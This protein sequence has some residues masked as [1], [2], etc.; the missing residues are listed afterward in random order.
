MLRD[1]RL[2]VTGM[3]LGV[4]LTVSSGR[5]QDVESSNSEVP[6]TVAAGTS[7][8]N[9]QGTAAAN[10]QANSG[11]RG[12]SAT[13]MQLQL[14]Q[15]LEQLPPYTFSFAPDTQSAGALK[16]LHWCGSTTMS[17]L[18]HQWVHRL[19]QMHPDIEII[20]SAEG[21]EIG[22]EKLA[23]DPTLLVGVSRPVDEEDLKRLLA[24][25][26]KEP[27]AV[28]VGLEAMAVFVHKSNPI[29]SVSPAI[30]RSIFAQQA[31]GT[32]QAKLWRDVGVE[33]ELATSTITV[34]ER[35]QNSGSEA[36]ISKVLLSGAKMVP[37]AKPCETNSAV[38]A[39]IAADPSGIGFGDLRYEHPDVRRVPLQVQG[40]IIQ[41]TDG[42]VLSGTYPLMR[43]LLLVMD[44]SQLGKDARLRESVLRFILSRN[45]QAEV[46]KAGFFPLDPGYNHHQ[47][48]ELFGD[49]LR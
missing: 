46:I 38:C 42:S 23:A 16:P 22:L 24:G 33:G 40:Q 27:I 10:V 2:C 31:D 13:P 19:R 20:S 47:L 8:A 14:A 48:N 15:M 17:E 45:G 4:A 36:F 32:P 1:A 28:L 6:T 25:K 3:I 29:E 39:A 37:T 12:E 35:G 41:A 7:S 26:C 30:I 21:S 9:L 18:G 49:Q 44:K 34:H 11:L 43:P 5:S